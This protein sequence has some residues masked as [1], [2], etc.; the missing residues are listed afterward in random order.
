[1]KRAARKFSIAD[2]RLAIHEVGSSPAELAKRLGCSR[3]TIYKYLRLPE[4]AEMRT[5]PP[6]SRPQK[7]R[8]AVEAAI[9]GSRGIKQRV[10]EALGVTRQTVDNYFVLWPDLMSVFEDERNALI[11]RAESKL[12]EAVEAGDMRATIFTLETLGKSRG[13]ARRTEVTGADGEAVVISRQTLEMIQSMGLD[14]GQ[15]V[16]EFEG[17]IRAAALEQALGLDKESSQK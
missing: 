10:A 3:G 13:W 14:A 8:E 16:R 9:R 11:D 17:F 1:M 4:L 12:A 15:V 2:I 6:K 7:T 5:D